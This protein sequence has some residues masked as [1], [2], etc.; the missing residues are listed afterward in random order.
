VIV[1][2]VIVVVIAVFTCACASV[3]GS[4]EEAQ[5]R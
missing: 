3:N 2:A 4:P 5:P 1:G